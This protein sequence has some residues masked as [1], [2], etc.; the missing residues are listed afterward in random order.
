MRPLKTILAVLGATALFVV[1]VT[2]GDV[3]RY[4]ARFSGSKVSILG[5]STIHDWTMDGQIIG[6]FMEVPAGVEFDQ[7]KT[8]LSGLTGGKLDARVETTIPV[9]SMKGSW[10]GMDEP[11]QD[12]MNAKEH[13]EIKFKLTE[14]TLKEPH[15]AGTPFQFEAKGELSLHGVTNLISMPASIESVDKSRLKISGKTPLKMTDFKV[16]PPVKLGIF[17]TGDEVTITFEWLVAQPKA[18]SPK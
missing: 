18:A 10:S 5:T 11:M 2:A 1:T 15:A 6:G 16:K 4:N 14:L 8:T 7:S 17:R 9:T 12:A 13:S 3:V